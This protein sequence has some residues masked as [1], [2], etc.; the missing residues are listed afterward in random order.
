MAWRFVYLASELL[1][2]DSS[3]G[4]QSVG[5]ITLNERYQWVATFVMKNSSWMVGRSNGFEIAG[6]KTVIFL[7]LL[8]LSN[9]L[10]MDRSWA[11]SIGVHQVTPVQLGE[12]NG[13]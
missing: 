5:R 11:V 8:R 3:L 7:D 4:R 10:F 9:P 13:K 1:D 2:K 12:S 6:I